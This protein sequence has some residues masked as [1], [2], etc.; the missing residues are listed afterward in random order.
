[1]V[2]C[3]LITINGGWNNLNIHVR[4]QLDFSEDR[5]Y[6]KTMKLDQDICYL[7]LQARDARFDGHFFTA[8][9]T[10]KIYCRP[11]CPARI[12]HRKNCLFLP[13]AAAAHGAGFRPCLRCRP[14]ISPN[15]LGRL[16]S[17]ST[18]FDRALSAIATGALDEFGVKELAVQLKV[19]DRH[20]RRLFSENL[21]ASPV[22]V[23]QTRRILFAKQLINETNLSMTDIAMAAGF[24]S[25]RRFNDVM[26][27]TYQK[28]PSALRK[29]RSATSDV[30]LSPLITLKLPFSP[31]YD[32]A[33][34]IKFLAGRAMPGIE[35]VTGDSYQRTISIDGFHGIVAVHPV[36]GE[37]YLIA[38]I[39]FPQVTALAMIVEK[40]RQ[41]FDLSANVTLISSQLASD[42]YLTSI[43]NANPGLRVPGA[44]DG[45]ELAVRAI[46]GQQISVAAATTLASR[47]VA[48]YGEPLE[49]G[50]AS[51]AAVDLQFVFPRPELLVGEDL[52]KLGV[53]TAR[54]KA[55]TSLA[56][57]MTE[58]PNTLS[59]FQTLEDAVTQLC[60]L[61]GIGEWT[62]QYIAMR[63]LRE[64]DAFPTGDLALLRSME[65]HEQPMTKSRLSELAEAWR[66][67]RAYAAMHLWSSG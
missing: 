47:L 6:A 28:P 14:E 63:L 23:A 26:Q 22:T 53:T 24:A 59:G 49:V 39:Q 8:V 9:L 34:L 56:A 29:L 15:L 37:N 19:S 1:L 40:L 36:A 42:P 66:P 67:W 11:I 55:I 16:D 65:K 21:G 35:S 17:G 54:S 18:V 51:R 30:S 62:A 52:T 58:N 20:L 10:T 44:W 5:V 57:M 3:L 27:K 7:A 25:I 64:P 61:P 2:L 60:K 38:S 43:V 12:P 13:S 46:L 33:T 45:F 48:T 32:W 4:K 50:D 41:V 31:P